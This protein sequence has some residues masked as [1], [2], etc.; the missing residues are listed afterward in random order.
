[1]SNRLDFGS[2]Q[3]LFDSALED[4]LKRNSSELEVEDIE[5]VLTKVTDSIDL[6]SDEISEVIFNSL[7]ETQSGAVRDWEN[8]YSDFELRHSNLWKEAL[9]SLHALI[10][11]SYEVGEAFARKHLEEE[12]GE[13]LNVLVALHSRAT[14]VSNEAL[15]LLKSGYADGAHARWRTLHEIAVTMEFLSYCSEVTVKKYLEHE[16][17]E[18]YKAM[19]QY[20]KYAERLGAEPCQ[21]SEIEELKD[22]KNNLIR[23][24]GKAF[25]G[26]Y[27]W[28]AR[29][30]NVKKPNFSSLEAAVGVDHL[31]PYYK[32]ASHN[33]HANPKGINFRLGL[34]DGTKMFLSGP[35]NFGL[36]DPGQ[37]VAISLGQVNVSLLHARL[38]MDSIVYSK[39]LL[40]YSELVRCEFAE[41]DRMMKENPLN[42]SMHTTNA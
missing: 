11:A 1:M 15:C 5:G 34:S 4:K 38:N 23:K 9:G 35:S 17:V 2:I 27:G 12:T 41:V 36:S 13:K 14:Q 16:A 20:Q 39:V 31:R 26:P 30:L 3:S 10:I 24:Y 28:A 6:V 8:I 29:K 18:S 32:M 33:V 42:K 37:G 25:F 40:K 22:V 7:R 19:L 21:E